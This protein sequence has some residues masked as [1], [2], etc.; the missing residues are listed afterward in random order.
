M[1]PSAKHN[2]QS[3]YSLLTA[4][5]QQKLLSAGDNSTRLPL[6]SNG[7][8]DQKTNSKDCDDIMTQSQPT[9]YA[10]DVYIHSNV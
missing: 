9:F 3:G 7:V 8:A 4:A 2:A 10:A 6:C 5:L 1:L